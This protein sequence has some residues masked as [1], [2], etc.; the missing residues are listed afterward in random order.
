MYQ[1][2]GAI[3]R[4]G[5]VSVLLL[6]LTF[7]SYANPLNLV[8]DKRWGDAAY[9]KSVS[10]GQYLYVATDGIL[11]LDLSES[12]SPQEFIK[13]PIDSS[14]RID[15]FEIIDDHLFI[16]TSS[17]FFIIDIADKSEIQ[18]LA[19]LTLTNFKN[20]RNFSIHDNQLFIVERDV[21]ED[22]STML[23]VY[24]L[25][26]LMSP[27]L[28][29]QKALPH[30]TRGDTRM[31]IMPNGLL[32]L[33]DNS[34]TLLSLSQD[35]FL[36]ELFTD[37]IEG[38]VY[39][40]YDHN[41]N[42]PALGGVVYIGQDNGLVA[43]DFSNT[44][45]V[46][47]HQVLTLE[48]NVSSLLIVGA[49]L[50]VVDE[51]NQYFTYDISNLMAPSVV[52]AQ[53]TPVTST[54]QSLTAHNGLVI[55]NNDQRLDILEN[56]SQIA[57]YSKASFIQD[58]GVT[59]T[60][61]IVS[62]SEVR[63]FDAELNVEN[64]HWPFFSLDS[65]EVFGQYLLSSAGALYDIST[66]QP[67]LLSSNVSYDNFDGSAFD[68]FSIEQDYLVRANEQ[69]I[70]R[71]S[72][73][74]PAEPESVETLNLVELTPEV[75]QIN[76][77]VYSSQSYFIAS[78]EGVFYY[79]NSAGEG[80][81][82]TRLGEQEWVNDVI[83]N[84]SALYSVTPN[85]Q[86]TVW[87]VSGNQLPVQL[88]SFN[89]R[90]NNPDEL[91]I[92]DNW[93]FILTSHRGIATYDVS[94]PEQPEFLFFAHENDSAYKQL[95]VFN[96]KLVARTDTQIS[97]I[98]LNKAPRILTE[99]VSTDEDVELVADLAVENTE[100]DT[101]AFEITQNGQSGVASISSEGRLSYQPNNNFN[102]NDVLVIK[103]TDEHGGE[104]T[105]QIDVLVSPINDSPV[106]QD[107]VFSVTENQT[108]TASLIATDIENDSL[109]FAVSEAPTSGSVVINDNGTFEYTP[110]ANFTGADSFTFS[111]TDNN[112]E[113][114]TGVANI[115][116]VNAPTPPPT[117][118]AQAS[119]GGGS[120]SFMLL[121]TLMVLL[122]NKL[123]QR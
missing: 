121:I 67:S 23:Q 65:F 30:G 70:A 41:Y 83:V 59:N 123:L 7:V 35:S 105:Q 6:L 84:Q 4:H 16:M 99:Q 85:G 3:M 117:V 78:P 93:L 79:T 75:T 45:N 74:N 122:R 107:N 20:W 8:L 57:S 56:L 29:E 44:S 119:S 116:V 80:T 120:M 114:V 97:V 98:S 61:I 81:T 100:D 96:E 89:I 10:D 42:V 109:T 106:I 43:Y 108:L 40:F 69:V 9:Q 55:A 51:L 26:N 19:N 104:S 50:Y 111:V 87:G 36:N 52:S 102:G 113:A 53:L 54:T 68:H 47:S 24:S 62:G 60:G 95:E 5:V 90:A 15:N 21:G 118:E 110:N 2:L 58:M 27:V 82:G 103:V 32:L 91:T 18:V 63:F 72:L 31:A 12:D 112:G 39:N 77:L 33:I 101:L 73:I 49:L 46:V 86:L 28:V 88:S 71:Y 115:T 11:V 17:E 76:S 38:S 37:V 92:V 94:V 1:Q 25:E 34:M 22:P 64:D 48:E 13:L 14:E 66:E